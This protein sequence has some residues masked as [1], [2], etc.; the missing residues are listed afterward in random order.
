MISLILLACSATVPSQNVDDNTTNNETENH[1]EEGETKYTGGFRSTLPLVL[2]DTQGIDVDADDLWEDDGSR[3][4]ALVDATFIN[5]DAEGWAYFDGTPEFSS[6]S[7]MHVRGNSSAGY[8]K[9]SYALETRDSDGQDLDVSLFG[10]PEEEDWVLHGP[11]SDKTLMRNVLM[12]TWS[13]R[14]GRYASRTKFIELFVEDGGDSLGEEDYRGV[15]V[16]MEKIKRD[17]N[18]VDIDKMEETD[19]SEPEIS[20]G[21]LLKKD[22]VEGGPNTYINTETYDD[23]LLLVDPD[24]DQITSQQRS[25]L[26]DWINEFEAVLAGPDFADETHGYAS[27]I[28]VDSFI[29]HHLMVELGRNVDGYVLS[30]WLYKERNGKLNMGP[31]WDYNGSLGNADYFES[32]DPEG[33]H[34]ENSEF[35]ADNPTAYNWYERLFEDPAFVERYAARWAELRASSLST[36]MLLADI[37]ANAA[38]LATPAERNF[39]RWDILGEYVWPNDFEAEER[40][41]YAEEVDYLKN[42]VTLRVQWMDQAV[43]DL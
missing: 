6:L 27:Y 12:Y 41:S 40:Q 26:Q 39:Q 2:I 4:W 1:E 22:W 30:T 32:W 18:R 36:E 23:V 42:W 20:G 17:E 15:Y 35:P 5:T 14:I 28:D 24:P 34:Y 19:N 10:L 29:D 37:D 8:E 11:Y 9:K 16:L 3:D 31:I 43:L 7:G 38:I 33:W 13:T 25:W 21:Y